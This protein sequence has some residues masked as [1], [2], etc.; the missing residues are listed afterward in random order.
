MRSDV[1]ID[2]PKMRDKHHDQ[3]ELRGD[4]HDE[5]QQHPEDV[6]ADDREIERH[7]DGDEEEAEQHVAEGLDVLLDLVA[8][9]GLGDQHAGQE[10]AQR[11][12][13]ARELRERREPERD[14]QQVQHEEL[15]ASLPRDQVE[16]RPHRLLSGEQDQHQR[17]RRLEGRQREIDREV[18]AG[19]ARATAG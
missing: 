18:G 1:P 12:R 9:L 14:Q 17:D 6:L 16:P 7:P 13:Q 4:G 15:G 10:R 3:H 8:V 2:A 19:L 11:E 5:Q